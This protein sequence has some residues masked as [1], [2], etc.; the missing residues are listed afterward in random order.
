M[1]AKEESTGL[2]YSEPSFSQEPSS[3]PSV[4]SQAAVSPQTQAAPAP[5]LPKKKV[6]I[7]IAGETFSGNFLMNWTRCLLELVQKNEYEVLLFP[8][9]SPFSPYMRLKTLGMETTAVK[10]KPFQGKEYDVFVSLDS[11]VMFS[12]EQLKRLIDQTDVYHAVTGYYMLNDTE[13]H[14]MKALFPEEYQGEYK[15]VPLS[16]V[17]EKKGASEPFHVEY[18][19]LGFFACRRAVLDAIEFPY[20]WYPLIEYINKDSK[21]CKEMLTDEM[22]FCQR[23]KDKRFLIVL[24]TELKVKQEKNVLY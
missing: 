10:S 11:T 17:E 2:T 16:D 4:S 9:Y 21:L 20:V 5:L 12:Y 8:G 7:G 24:D 15:M 13:V 22:A 1:D 18:T 14:A 19:G 6:M 3:Q 23:I